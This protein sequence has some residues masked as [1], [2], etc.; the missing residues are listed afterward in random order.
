MP[1]NRFSGLL[2]PAITPFDARLEPD[3]ALFNRF[4]AWLIGQGADGLAVFGTT[5]EANSLSLRE[6]QHMLEELVASGVPAGRLLPG[7]GLC[8]LADTV[9]LTDHALRVGCGGVL[10]LPPFYYK[11]VSD[12]GL[13]TY[14]SEVIERVGSTD[15]GVWL[16]NIPQTSGVAISPALVERLLKRYPATV[17]GL[18]DSAGKW[19][20]TERMIRAFPGFSV[21][22]SSEASVLK[23]M[24]IGGAGCITASGNINARA[25]RRLIDARGSGEEDM[26]QEGVAAVRAAVSVFELIPAVKAV[27]T[28]LLGQA[29]LARLR[30]PLTQ[31]A[32]AE[33]HRLLDSLRPMLD[34]K[35]T[36]N[37]M[38]KQ[39]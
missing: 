37:T 19:D 16:Y 4:C 27:A 28:E 7:T 22:P 20:D 6:R 26:L 10:L 12:E 13:F 14:Y 30:P 9:M 39:S 23:A 1:K 3:I 24:A 36:D 34:F 18:K 38:E 2:V 11:P 35:P 8:A 32:D 5:S 15:L 31:L 33:R 21:F 17:L 29:N 25:I